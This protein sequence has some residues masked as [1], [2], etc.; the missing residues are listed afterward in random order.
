MLKLLVTP[1]EILCF[2][3][4]GLERKALGD[5]WSDMASCKSHKR[6]TVSG[7]LPHAVS[8]TVLGKGGELKK[9]DA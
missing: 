3:R 4:Q 9:L 8:L 5:Q 1:R 2:L 7:E 6:C